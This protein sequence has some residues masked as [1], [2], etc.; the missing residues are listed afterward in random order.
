MALI[1]NIYVL[2]VKEDVEGDVETVTHPTESG[3]PITDSVRKKPLGINISGKIA[4]TENLTAKQAVE[5]LTKLRDEGSVIKYIG[6]CG[7]FN[8]LQIQSFKPSYHHKNF[9]GADFSMSL[10]AFKTAKNAYV[11]PKITSTPT[12]E[13]KVGGKVKFWGG[14]VYV[15]SDAEGYSATRGS[16]ICE[17]TQISTLAN[18][19]H[20]YHL[21]STDCSYGSSHYV[22][23]WV[24]AD[25]V[26]SIPSIAAGTTNGGTQQV[27]S[28]SSNNGVKYHTVKKGDTIYS[29]C[30]LTYKGQGYT[31]ARVIRDNPTAFSTPNDPTTLIIGARLELNSGATVDRIATAIANVFLR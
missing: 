13:I 9:G 11:A 31:T 6:Q 24:D 10:K 15:S 5:K 2:A 25:K 23:G 1:N 8:N 7:S 30:Y 21:K 29:I 3:F 14:H 26:S 27:Q 16:S 4:D 18:A 22:Y 17:L 28:S 19:K 12:M 20:I